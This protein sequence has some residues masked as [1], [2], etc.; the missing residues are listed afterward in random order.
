M[1]VNREQPFSN[2]VLCSF[3]KGDCQPRQRKPVAFQGRLGT[4]RPAPLGEADLEHEVVS[5]V[6]PMTPW[7]ASLIL[8]PY[9][10]II[11]AL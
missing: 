3:H 6:D 4:S 11:A 10:T 8:S 2:P 7:Y 5:K 9:K 1:L